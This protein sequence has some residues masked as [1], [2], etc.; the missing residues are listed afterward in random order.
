MDAIKQTLVEHES[1][2]KTKNLDFILRTLDGHE[3]KWKE[4]RSECDTL[5]NR[6]K[7]LGEEIN[8]RIVADQ[9][10]QF[11]Q[12]TNNTRIETICGF[13]SISKFDSKI[14]SNYKKENDLIELCKVSDKQFKLLYR[15]TRDGFQASNWHAKCDNQPR[16]LS[17]QPRDTFSALTNVM[18][19][20]GEAQAAGKPTLMRSYS[21]S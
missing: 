7:S 4:I 6:I 21:V 20:L 17:R 18:Q 9:M 12:S 16:K 19:S 14:I 13:L 10:I 11:I 8:E 1:A 3:A 5:L 2:L 15:A